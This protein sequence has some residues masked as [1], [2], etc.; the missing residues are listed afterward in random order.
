M[1]DRWA[2]TPRRRVPPD[3]RPRP[4]GPDLQLFYNVSVEGIIDNERLAPPSWWFAETNEVL[5]GA[6]H[7]DGRLAVAWLTFLGLSLCCLCFV[8]PLGWWINEDKQALVRV[9]LGFATCFA[10]LFFG[11]SQRH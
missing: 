3:R 11:I 9:P 8:A 4:S 7:I 6:E 10:C 2:Q 1:V 5:F